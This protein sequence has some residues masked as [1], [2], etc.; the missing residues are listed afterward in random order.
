MISLILG[1]GLLA[2]CIWMLIRLTAPSP[3]DIEVLRARVTWLENRVTRL[4]TKP[5]K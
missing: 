5:R 4:E 3:D 2:W 1:L